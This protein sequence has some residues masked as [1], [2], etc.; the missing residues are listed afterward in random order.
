[1]PL[2]E[3]LDYSIGDVQFAADGKSLWLTAEDRGVVPVFK[4]NAD[5]TGLTPVHADR[6]LDRPHGRS[7]DA[8]SS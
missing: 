5:G 3:S 7:R 2:T 4:L 6:H 8:W 1:M